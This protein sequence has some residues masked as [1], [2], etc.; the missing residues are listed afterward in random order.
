MMQTPSDKERLVKPLMQL[1]VP[2][3][4][5]AV[6]GLIGC[7]AST[8][9]IPGLPDEVVDYPTVTM[10]QVTLQNAVAIQ[11]PIVDRRD[12]FLRKITLPL[13]SRSN[14][15]LHVEWRIL[16]YG[17]DGHPV[18]PEMT[19][20]RMMLDP[21]QPHRITVTT[22]AANATDYNMQLRWARP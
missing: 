19:W 1:A 16:W 18:G 2:V 17:G 6:L 3:I 22:M 9:P 15:P 8:G 12:G 10:S 21:R 4:A 20:R 14:E 11:Q 13:R 5:V 7:E